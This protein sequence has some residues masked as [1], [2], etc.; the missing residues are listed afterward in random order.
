MRIRFHRTVQ[1]SQ[2]VGSALNRPSCRVEPAV[3]GFKSTREQILRSAVVVHVELGSSDALYIRGA[4]GPLRD[5]VGQ[6]LN[7]IE[8]G[9]WMWSTGALSDRFE[10]QLLLNDQVW[11]RGQPHVLERGHTIHIA[12]DFEWPDI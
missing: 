1:P 9:T 8:P 12:P 6:R 10:F 5:D 7:C 11:E 2:E 4:G 3:C